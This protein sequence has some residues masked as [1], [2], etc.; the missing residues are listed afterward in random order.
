MDKERVHVKSVLMV[1]E[2]STFNAGNHSF[3]ARSISDDEMAIAVNDLE[4]LVSNE[5]YRLAETVVALIESKKD[6]R[7]MIA[8][9]LKVDQ[10]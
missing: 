2:A 8:K 3:G 7:D 5:E 6:V 4:Y 10:S 9:I 1:V